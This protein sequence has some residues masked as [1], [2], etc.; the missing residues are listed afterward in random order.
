MISEVYAAGRNGVSSFV[1]VEEGVMAHYGSH[2]WVSTDADATGTVAFDGV[3]HEADDESCEAM[4]V[5]CGLMM[6]KQDGRKLVNVYTES[7]ENALHDGVFAK[8]IEKHAEGMD[9]FWDVWSEHCYKPRQKEYYANPHV[10]YL[11]ELLTKNDV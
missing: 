4:A 9:V 5:V 3:E 7:V 11:R 1:V 6:C 8:V 10:A 2:R